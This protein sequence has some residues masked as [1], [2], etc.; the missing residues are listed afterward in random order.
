MVKKK[1]IK[2]KLGIIYEND[3]YL[4]FDTFIKKNNTTSSTNNKNKNCLFL[5]YSKII[6]YF[7]H[8]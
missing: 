8:H 3:I 7:K 2:N 1:K 5:L 4:D 6:N